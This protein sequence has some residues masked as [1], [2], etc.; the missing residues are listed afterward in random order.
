MY[1]AVFQS[2]F[3]SNGNKTAEHT[4][5]PRG[6]HYTEP[7]VFVLYCIVLYYIVQHVAWNCCMFSR[8][9]SGVG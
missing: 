1:P 9:H 8:L 4:P 3:L 6:P 2:L 7:S 5:Q